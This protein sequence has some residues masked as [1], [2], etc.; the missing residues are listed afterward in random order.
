MSDVAENLCAQLGI[1]IIPC[2]ATLGPNT[3]DE[4]MKAVKDDAPLQIAL[5]ALLAVVMVGCSS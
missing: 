5:L 1:R 2:A 4:I 3:T